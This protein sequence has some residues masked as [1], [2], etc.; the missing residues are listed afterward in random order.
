[1][2]LH[3]YG[4]KAWFIKL[5][6]QSLISGAPGEQFNWIIWFLNKQL[7]LDDKIMNTNYEEYLLKQVRESLFFFPRAGISRFSFSLFSSELHLEATH[8]KGD[9]TLIPSYLKVTDQVQGMIS[10]PPNKYDSYSCREAVGGDG[11][12]LWSL[13]YSHMP[14]PRPLSATGSHTLI[15][16]LLTVGVNTVHTHCAH[17]PVGGGGGVCSLTSGL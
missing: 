14:Y 1:M 15:C 3:I 11:K 5:A 8:N 17:L 7:Q 16:P 4:H 10:P 13:F 2:P 9:E 6:N 12:W